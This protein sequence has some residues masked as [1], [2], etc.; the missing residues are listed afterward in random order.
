[1]TGES[2]SAKKATEILGRVDPDQFNA[3]LE[4][5]SS[6]ERQRK[7]TMKSELQ[8][9]LDVGVRELRAMAREFDLI[10]PG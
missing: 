6:A 5:A 9:R 2:S 3:R 7:A 8:K 10:W 4:E 1:M